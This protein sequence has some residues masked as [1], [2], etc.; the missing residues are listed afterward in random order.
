MGTVQY[1]FSNET[2]LVTG[3]SSGVGKLVSEDFA[4]SGGN[5]VCIGRNRDRLEGVVSRINESTNGSAVAVVGDV[6]QSSTFEEAVDTAVTTFGG[7]NYAFNCAGTEGPLSPISETTDDSFTDMINTKLTG[8]FLGLKAQIP[9]MREK[10]GAIVNMVGSFGHIGYPYMGA[11]CA[12]AHGV[13]GLTRTAALEEGKN[14]IRVNAVC[15]GAV[16][17]DLLTR[18]MGGDKDAGL[19]IGASTALG[20]IASPADVSSAVMYLLSDSA[21]YMTG[22]YMMLDGGM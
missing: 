12:A 19:A 11:Y 20:R 10:G 14:K 6:S 9:V 7:L 21:V 4:T 13:L 5:V 17:T 16:E 3:A 18:M 15:P 1:D 2:L 8:C 22:T